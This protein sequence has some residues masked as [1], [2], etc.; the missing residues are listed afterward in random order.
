MAKYYAPSGKFNPIAFL[1]FILIALIALPILGLAYAYAIWYIPFIYINFFI[2]LA[3]SFLIGLTISHGVV[4]FGKIRN[5]P[6]TIGLSFLAGIMALYFHWAVWVDL[7]INAGESYGSSRIGITVSNIKLF[8]TFNLAL[9]PDVL[10]GFIGEINQYG[11][12]GFKSA[13]VSGTFLTIIWVIEAL[14]ILAPATLIPI[15]YASEPFCELGN[16][17]FKEKE[18]PAFNY[19]ETPTQLV[20]AIENSNP[21]A[22]KE[23]SLANNLE[24]NHSI[25]SLY[26]SNHNE[27]YLS[28]KNKRATTNKKGE[29]EFNNDAFLEYIYLNSELTQHL[30]T[31]IAK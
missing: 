8:Q 18:L 20:K 27:N 6:L 28:I 23:L 7:V 10:F 3:F 21:E 13:T 30:K 5:V 4:K 22:F 19:I 15:G 9:Q 25:F 29:L 1:Y 17:W 24:K 31:L 12:W 16:A 14:I 2:A 11:T 26:S